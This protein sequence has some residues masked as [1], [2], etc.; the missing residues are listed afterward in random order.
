MR[1][2][3]GAVTTKYK[4]RSGSPSL[5]YSL[6]NYN[7]RIRRAAVINHRSST[8][9]QSIKH[10]RNTSNPQATQ[11]PPSIY[12]SD[13]KTN[14]LDTSANG[15]C[16]LTVFLCANMDDPDIHTRC[17]KRTEPHSEKKEPCNHPKVGNEIKNFGLCPRTRWESSATKERK[18]CPTC[19]KKKED[20]QKEEEERQRKE[21]EERRRSEER[22]Q[23]QNTASFVHDHLWT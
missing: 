4:T 15:M 16:V 7:T 8:I 21:D 6:H 23:E 11:L 22:K 2:R 17:L 14:S 9:N 13:P 12:D 20:A 5:P 10:D 1:Q 18:L 3:T 19:Q